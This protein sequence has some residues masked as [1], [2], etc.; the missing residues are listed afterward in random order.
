MIQLIGAGC[1]GAIIGWYVYYINRYRKGDV[2]FSDLTTVVGI[3]GGAGITQLFGD[4]SATLFGAYGIG[5]F[6]GFFGYFV[7]LLLLVK[8]SSSFDSDWFLDGRRIA[9]QPPYHIPGDLRPSGPAMDVPSPSHELVTPT[10]VV[11]VTP[12]DTASL[13]DDVVDKASEIIA[14][15][16]S[17]WDANKSDCSGFV[18]A[19]CEQFQVAMTGQADNII[20]QIQSAGWTSLSDGVAAKRAADQGQLVICGLRGASLTPPNSHG[21][22][23][24]VVSGALA[25]GKYPTAYW[26]QLG[27]VGRKKETLNYAFKK[28][29]RD[30]VIYAGKTV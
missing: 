5:L 1:F 20:D 14:A 7:S 26:G 29:D 10:V 17:V 19:V 8:K 28:V 4:G 30:K 3:I 15:C 11:N 25:H 9:P 24:V 27:G 18:K 21:H 23:A 13:D 16:E 12:S 22:V 6:S 2:Q